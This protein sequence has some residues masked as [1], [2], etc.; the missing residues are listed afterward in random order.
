[1]LFYGIY[2]VENYKVVMYVNNESY[3]EV[4][5]SDSEIIQFRYATG[6]RDVSIEFKMV[7]NI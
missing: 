2:K 5:P 3:V 4:V 1:V 6:Y 7:E